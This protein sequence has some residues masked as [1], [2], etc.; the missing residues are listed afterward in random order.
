ML[1]VLPF[2]AEQTREA[3]RMRILSVLYFSCPQVHVFNFISDPNQ[4]KEGREKLNRTLQD[5]ARGSD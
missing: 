2:P 1:Q 5:G 4:L 3:D